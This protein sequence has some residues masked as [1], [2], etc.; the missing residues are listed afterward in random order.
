[1]DNGGYSQNGRSLGDSPTARAL[2]CNFS[3]QR[4][5]PHLA[6]HFF[7]GYL[8]LFL[9]KKP[10]TNE[11]FSGLTPPSR[12]NADFGFHR[13]NISDKGLRELLK[14]A[15]VGNLWR[16]SGVWR[17]YFGKNTELMSMDGVALQ[18]QGSK[19]VFNFQEDFLF[20][21]FNSRTISLT[22]AISCSFRCLCFLP[23]YP[24]TAAS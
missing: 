4:S 24:C 11:N 14:P 9:A 7:L 10:H 5:L 20:V 8:F 1:M 23:L 13:A 21:Q 18:S 17:R 19:C 2:R 3:S 12:H 6:K 22:S 15:S 16:S